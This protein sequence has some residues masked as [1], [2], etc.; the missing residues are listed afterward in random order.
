MHLLWILIIEKIY[1]EIQF[2]FF[3]LWIFRH[4]D[5]IFFYFELDKR[6]V[7][8]FQHKSLL[9]FCPFKIQ[10]AF[11]SSFA[12]SESSYFLSKRNRTHF[13]QH[14]KIKFQGFQNFANKISNVPL[15]QYI[16]DIYHC[17]YQHIIL[18]MFYH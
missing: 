10:S 4:F 13:G 7:R 18:L 11:Q 6:Y 16:L 17:G 2:I 5:K 3:S 15:T 14:N 8:I 1:L 12:S 9:L